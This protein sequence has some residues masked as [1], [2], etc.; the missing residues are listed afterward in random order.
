MMPFWIIILTISD[1]EPSGM[2][3]FAIG[4]VNVIMDWYRI[5]PKMTL[6]MP[7]RFTVAPP[8]RIAATAINAIFNGAM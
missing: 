8:I 4:S 5:V 6:K 2:I 7:A 3:T 1:K